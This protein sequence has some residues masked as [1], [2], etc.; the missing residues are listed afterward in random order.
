MQNG[1]VYNGGSSS[2]YT[3]F[4]N[5]NKPSWIYSWKDYNDIGSLNMGQFYINTS[6]ISY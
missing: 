6:S 4:A 1:V 5:S 3:T 2:G